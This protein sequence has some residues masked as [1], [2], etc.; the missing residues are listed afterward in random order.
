MTLCDG[1]GALIFFSLTYFLAGASGNDSGGGGEGD[2]PYL[3]NGGIEGLVLEDSTS[4]EDPVPA[5]NGEQVAA[6]GGEEQATEQQ[7]PPQTGQGDFPFHT[8]TTIQAALSLTS[9]DW[10][11]YLAVVSV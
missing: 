11:L 1:T 4:M 10:F 7:Q 2:A 6:L 9:H 5:N 8:T 3:P